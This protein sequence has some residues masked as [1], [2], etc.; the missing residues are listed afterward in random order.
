MI[1]RIL[2]VAAAVLSAP[3]ARALTLVFDDELLVVLASASPDS[4]FVGG[5][6]NTTLTIDQSSGDFGGDGVSHALVRFLDYAV[7]STS[8][9]QSARL[10]FYTTDNTPGPVDVYQMTSDW[11]ASSTWNSFGGDGLTPGGEAKA[12]P[13]GSLTG[14]G[15]FP[16]MEAVSFDVT[17]AVQAW[18]TG[19]NN[20]GLGVIN[21]SDDGWDVST[22]DSDPRFAPR[23]VVE[24][25]T[26][27]PAKLQ[28]D[29]NTGSARFV[30]VVTGFPIELRSYEILSEAGVLDP[31]AWE[32]TNLDARNVDA[33]DPPAIGDRWDTVAATAGQL[34]E[35]NLLGGS[36]LAPDATLSIGKILAPIGVMT[37]PTLGVTLVTSNYL[38][39]ADEFNSFDN[40][41]VEYAS[42][43][44]AP[45]DYN[46]DGVVDAADYTVWRDTLGQSGPGLAADGDGDN[47]VDS[48]D[49]QV[50]K[51]NFGAG[52]PSVGGVA[53]QALA[54][55]EPAAA[56]LAA[57][58]GAVVAAVSL[59]NRRPQSC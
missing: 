47:S 37:P 9:I 28:I 38:G 35:A 42:F 57:L 44:S 13:A 3:S 32:A 19:E 8:V 50:W 27:A 4:T 53:S 43:G 39:G 26:P 20:F 7:P 56:G 2:A 33:A 45:G 52:A 40:V 36:T 41:I 49:Y 24:V 48:D 46:L 5:V 59:I 17:P 25:L 12:A 10:E 54:V 18:G 16:E 22:V 30:S 31:V 23:L 51:L 14:S 15:S 29:P 58:A 1:F 34:F 21:T 6:G 55:P 11:G